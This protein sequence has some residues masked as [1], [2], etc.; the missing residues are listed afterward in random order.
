MS[1]FAKEVRRNHSSSL[2]FLT[3]NVGIKIEKNVFQTYS[4]VTTIIYMYILI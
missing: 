3:I 2:Y 4:R 1:V